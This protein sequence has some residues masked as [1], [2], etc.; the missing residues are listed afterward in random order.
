M[1]KFDSISFILSSVAF[2]SNCHI[3]IPQM[4][5]KCVIKNKHF[6]I[7]YPKILLHLP[8]IVF[9]WFTISMKDQ[10]SNQ[11]IRSMQCCSTLITKDY[12]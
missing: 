1:I 12:C 8:L 5:V 4:L 2:Y 7:Y 6:T 10:N 11:T 9:C 3:D